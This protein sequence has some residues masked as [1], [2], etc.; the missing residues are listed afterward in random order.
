MLMPAI[1]LSHIE[2]VCGQILVLPEKL[3]IEL[4]RP[5]LIEG[6]KPKKKIM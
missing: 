6:Y 3:I 5:L 4:Y 1:S 2:S